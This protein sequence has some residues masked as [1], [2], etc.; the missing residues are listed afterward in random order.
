M[1]DYPLKHR[2]LSLELQ[3]FE[4]EL[5]TIIKNPATI[6]QMVAAQTLGVYKAVRNKLHFRSY[7]HYVYKIFLIMMLNLCT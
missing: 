6:H 5:A 3:Y 2:I 1:L 4:T 7:L